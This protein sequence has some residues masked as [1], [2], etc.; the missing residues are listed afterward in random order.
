MHKEVQ[1]RTPA[2]VWQGTG[3]PTNSE[4]LVTDTSTRARTSRQRMPRT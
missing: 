3:A 2:L 1:Q 4:P